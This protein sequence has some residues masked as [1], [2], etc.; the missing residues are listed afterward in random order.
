M[1]SFANLVAAVAALAPLGAL[2]A[3][4]PAPQ[5][6]GWDVT[7][8]SEIA[9]LISNPEAAN[10]IPNRYIVVYNTSFSEDE[11]AATEFSISSLIA[12]R[13][14]GKRS[15]DGRQMSGF[16]STMKFTS[17]SGTGARF[18]AFD[19]DNTM[20]ATVAKDKTVAY[21]EADAR[22]QAAALVTE[23]GSTNGLARISS[24]KAGATDY[25]FDDSAGQGITAYI[26]D[27]GVLAT[28]SEF[29]GRATMGFNAIQGSANTDENGHG[30][31]VAGTV[32]GKTFG[33]AKKATIIGVKVLD[34]QGGGSNSGVLQGLQFVQTDA[35]KK[36]GKAVMNMSLGGPA[37]RAINSAVEAIAAAGVVPVVAAGNENQDAAN[38]S[39]ASSPNAITV[40]A[41]D[42]TN[43]SKASFSNFG[44]DVD[45]FAPG[46][47]VQSV[48]IKSNTDTATLSGTSMASP[49]VAGL[50]AYLMALE[51]LQGVQAVKARMVELATATGAQVVRN[52]RGTTNLI[53]NNGAAAGAGAAAPG[54]GA[55]TGAGAG[56]GTAPAPTQ[57]A[58]PDAGAGAG[59]GRPIPAGLPAATDSFWQSKVGSAI[60]TLM[61]L[62]V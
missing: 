8:S 34:A 45:I 24:N 3:P 35:A 17:A 28:H 58:T 56:N 22:V 38:V 48:G 10:I 55:G 53:A 18:S 15:L 29:E 1:P 52:T 13:N 40:G 37:S 2:A 27:T 39:P 33:V 43:D 16:M 4:T 23:A 42:Q 62:S 36:N 9:A 44:A 14:L 21:I 25:V 49:H 59:N 57:P 6:E 32:A 54:A 20:L 5:P 7:I 47:R 61:G 11:I 50:A 19:G 26:V 30:S 46:V 12:K 41:I 51:N 31:H 60:A